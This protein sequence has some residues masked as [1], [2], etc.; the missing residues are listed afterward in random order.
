LAV[1]TSERDAAAGGIA[2]SCEQFLFFREFFQSG[3][4]RSH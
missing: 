4:A 2:G 3:I 1:W